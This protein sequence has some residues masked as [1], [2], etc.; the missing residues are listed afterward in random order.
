MKTRIYIDVDGVLNAFHPRSK[1]P[2]EIAEASGWSSWKSKRVNGYVITW[3]E[4]LVDELNALA[5][6]DDIEFVWLTTWRD[7]ARTQISPALLLDGHNWRFLT[8][9]GEATGALWGKPNGPWWKLEVVREDVIRDP[10]DNIV[11]ID[12][13][14]P[15]YPEALEWASERGVVAVAPSQF[16]GLTR[17]DLDDILKVVNVVQS[18][19]AS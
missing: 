14:L 9:G 2:E 4:E 19:T 1:S 13:D 5:A 16:Y 12:D 8:D 3:S 15:L 10:V 11:W 7:E 6:R 17:E 18:E